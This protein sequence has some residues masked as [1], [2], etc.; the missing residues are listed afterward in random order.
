MKWLTTAA[1]VLLGAHRLVGLLRV[2]LAALAGVL[3]APELA[4]DPP[5]AP[6]PSY[7]A[8]CLNSPA[9]TPYNGP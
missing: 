3:L 2:A 9:P 8:S 6:A 4:G 7:Y 5:A 1:D